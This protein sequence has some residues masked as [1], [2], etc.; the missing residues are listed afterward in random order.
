MWKSPAFPMP[1][2]IGLTEAQKRRTLKY[3]AQYS[4][5]DMKW[6]QFVTNEGRPRDMFGYRGK[7]ATV[8]EK[9]LQKAQEYYRKQLKNEEEYC[10]RE[11]SIHGFTTIRGDLISNIELE[12]LPS[13]PQSSS[14][15]TEDDDDDDEEKKGDS[16]ANH[17]STQ[18]TNS[19]IP[20]PKVLFQTRNLKNNPC[21]KQCKLIKKLL[22]IIK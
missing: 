12:S 9:K 6:G 17:D 14:P 13:S 5:H 16:P 10:I 2:Q 11:L 7:T 4:Q 3:Y 20:T 18:T 8:V 22:K 21:D 19:E 1:K 15:T